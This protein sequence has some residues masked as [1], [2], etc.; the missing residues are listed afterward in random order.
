MSFATRFRYQATVLLLALSVLTLH[1]QKTALKGDVITVDKVPYAKL[2]KSGSML[3]R[4]YTL[5]TLDD[6]EVMLAKSVFVSLPNNDRFVYYT[7]T[8]RPG[9]EVAEMP[10]PGLG[11]SQRLAEAIVQQGVMHDGQPDP[12]GIARFVKAYSEKYSEKYAKEKQDQLDTP[13][14]GYQVVERSRR[15]P[16][17]QTFNRRLNRVDVI[18][19]GKLL[20][21]LPSAGNV[22]GRVTYQVFLPGGLVIAVITVEAWSGGGNTTPYRILTKRTN[23][24]HDRTASGGVESCRQDAVQ[25]LIMQG[26]L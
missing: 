5:T 19:D 21:Y 17:E 7:L 1:A 11:I 24:N 2:K 16:V 25:W 26:L 18:Q 15:A 8:F 13:P 10:S 12:A 14:L 20:G 6:K 4:D 22:S 23:V 9:G 3:M